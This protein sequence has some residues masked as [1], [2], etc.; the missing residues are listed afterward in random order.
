MMIICMCGS[1]AR[2]A[3]SIVGSAP[4][5]VLILLLLVAAAIGYAT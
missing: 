1:S 5:I 2:L 4:T 3:M